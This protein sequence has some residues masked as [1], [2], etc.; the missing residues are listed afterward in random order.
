MVINKSEKLTP[1]LNLRK[2][3]QNKILEMKGKKGRNRTS[4]K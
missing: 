2:E 1:R 4:S 3:N